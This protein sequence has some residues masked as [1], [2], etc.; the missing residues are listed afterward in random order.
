MLTTIVK[1]EARLQQQRIGSRGATLGV[2]GSRGR[3]GAGAPAGGG[4]VGAG[5]RGLEYAAI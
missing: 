5:D 2:P 4:G 1:E 3:D